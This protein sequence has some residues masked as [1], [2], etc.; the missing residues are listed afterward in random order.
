MIRKRAQIPERD[1]KNRRI[2]QRLLPFFREADS[3]GIYVPMGAEA[4]AGVD[5]NQTPPV[6]PGAESVR[7]VV[8]KVTDETTIR[9]YEPIC[10]HPGCF[11]V[12]EPPG[13]KQGQEEKVPDVLVI[14]M[15]RFCRGYR[16][17]YGK[18]Y[19]DRYLAK[20]PECIRIGIAYDEQEDEFEPADWDERLDFLITPTSTRF[21]PRFDPEYSDQDGL[22]R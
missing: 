19:Y 17:G 11:G 4:D 3:V 18:G 22:S 21:W 20:H 16:T 15:L 2:A 13:E 8:P 10:L 6:F 5:W 1:R 7:I 9:F 12:Q 14:P